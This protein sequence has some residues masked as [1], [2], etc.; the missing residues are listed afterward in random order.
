M[1]SMLQEASS[2]LKAVE[3]AWNEA[4]NPQEFTIK[5]LEKGE[6]G[7]LGLSGGRPAVVSITYQPIR[8]IR[9]PREFVQKDAFQ[10]DKRYQQQPKPVTQVA[11]KPSG[12]LDSLFG[13]KVEKPQQQQRPQQQKIVQP[14]S[15]QPAGQSKRM[16]AWRKEFVDNVSIWLKEMMQIMGV[17]VTIN[18]KHDQRILNVFID[19][20]V[21]KDSE[22][23]KLFFISLSHLLMQ[24]LKRKYKK[25]FANYYLIIH[26]KTENNDDRKSVPSNN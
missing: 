23:E 20:R 7:F 24:F 22:E 15:G 18:F 12:I 25:K 2:V 16:D 4:G 9:K 17:D 1:K 19:K 21:F 14:S 6:K 26:S 11:K 8:D 13:K 5:I 10:K 3:K